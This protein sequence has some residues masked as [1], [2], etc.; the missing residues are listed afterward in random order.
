MSRRIRELVRR[1]ESEVSRMSLILSMMKI[2][3][4]LKGW[5]EERKE[6]ESRRPPHHQGCRLI[7]Q[8]LAHEQRQHL[9]I[10]QR[11]EITIT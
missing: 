4:I 10:L 3:Q 5:R 11:M 8:K 1:E 2:G 7:I 6:A 9:Q